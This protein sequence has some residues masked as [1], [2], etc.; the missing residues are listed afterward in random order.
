MTHTAIADNYKKSKDLNIRNSVDDYSVFFYL[1]DLKEKSILD[2]ACGEGHYTRKFAEQG[3]KRVVGVDLS[4]KMVELAKKEEEVNKQKIEY[5]I[6]DASKPMEH[7][8]QFD[9]VTGIFLLHYSSSAEQLCQFTTQ[10]FKRLLP[11]GVFVGLN[12]E[13]LSINFDPHYYDAY[14]FSSIYK[15]PVHDASIIKVSLKNK[16]GSQVSFFSFNFSR[17]T[18]LTCFKKSGFKKIEF[19]PILINPNSIAQY[20]WNYWLNFIKK[21]PVM[22]I[23]AY[24]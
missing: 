20:G 8:G 2:L 5:F 21:P 6:N 19:L 17:D 16:D 4:K 10:I 12:A 18:Y 15:K 13:P 7:L 11:N 14:H 24:K 22:I 23:K 1:G 3:A 9:L